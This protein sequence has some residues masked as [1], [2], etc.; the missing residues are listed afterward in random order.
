MVRADLERATREELIAYLESW[1]YQCYDS[2][3]TEQLL[4]AALDNFDLEGE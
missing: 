4:E 1:G 2:E 3:T